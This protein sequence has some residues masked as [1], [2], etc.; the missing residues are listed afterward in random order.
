M[1]PYGI[2]SFKFSGHRIFWQRFFYL[3]RSLLGVGLV[4]LCILCLPICSGVDYV[5]ALYHWLWLPQS[6]GLPRWRQSLLLPDGW[7]DRWIAADAHVKAKAS[8][9][10]VSQYTYVYPICGTKSRASLPFC[11]WKLV[12]TFKTKLVIDPHLRA[13]GCQAGRG[14]SKGVG[15]RARAQ[16]AK[17]AYEK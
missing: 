15:E 10:C 12:Y 1:C 2:K 13:A 5:A 11:W 3:R 14:R 6:E 4:A 16:V 8:P 7:M 17:G 9:A